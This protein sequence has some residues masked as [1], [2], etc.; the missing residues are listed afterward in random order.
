MAKLV[1]FGKS[2]FTP[3]S[4]ILTNV[5]LEIHDGVISKITRFGTKPDIEADIVLPGFIDPHVHCRDGS[6]SQKETI[7]TAG[8]AAA[9]GGVTQIHDMPNTDPPILG[10]SDV[11]ARLERAGKSGI[12]VKYMMYAGL[13]S[14]RGQIRE[15]VEAVNKYQQV[16][17]LKLYAG[18]SVGGLGVTEPGEQEKVY[19]S[20]ARLKYTGMLMVHCEKTS[21]FLQ[22]PW[23]VNYPESWCDIRPPAA[24]LSSVKDQI[25]FATK[26]GF[27]GR[28]HVCHVTMPESLSLL[29]DAPKSLRV[30]CGVTPHHLMFSR[31]VMGR[32]RGLF[33]KVNPPLRSRESVDKLATHL[34][35]GTIRFIETDHAPHKISEKLGQ[36]FASGMPELDTYSNFISLLYNRL[37]IHLEDLVKLTSGNA[38]RLFGLPGHDIEIGNVANLSLLDM[39]PETVNK[40]NLLT[41]CG[42]SPYEGMTFPGRCKGTIV[43][44]KIVY[45]EL[46]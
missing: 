1:V 33:Y 32:A 22:E 13:T 3:R 23:R 27:R 8:L 4:G 15:A 40:E 7:Q 10:K 9:H 45:R 43:N 46:E 26:A 44:G 34:T 24:E 19:E 16:A 35:S 5:M 20:L 30:S 25:R 42:W 36:P 28:L 37:H 38:Q 11:E 41:R 2:V 17:G 18:E 31:E 6:Q 21:A 12:R 39:K 29:R 14:R